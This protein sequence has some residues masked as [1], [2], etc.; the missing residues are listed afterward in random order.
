MSQTVS[1]SGS[2]ASK[3]LLTTVTAGYSDS[4]R[5]N[6]DLVQKIFSDQQLIITKRP[7]RQES[8][9]ENAE[10]PLIHTGLLRYGLVLK[11]SRGGGGEHRLFGLSFPQQRFPSTTLDV[12]KFNITSPT[13][14]F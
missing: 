9:F 12:N 1:V 14:Q 3:S 8:K 11:S 6:L 13:K 10:N 7:T 4:S 2:T 5:T